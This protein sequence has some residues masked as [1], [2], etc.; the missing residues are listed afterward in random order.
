MSAHSYNIGFS[1]DAPHIL[2]FEIRGAESLT[3][4]QLEADMPRITA[5]LLAEHEKVC[6]L[7]ALQNKE[8]AA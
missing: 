6:G 2:H 7:F 4:E 8:V 1:F 3:R 5:A